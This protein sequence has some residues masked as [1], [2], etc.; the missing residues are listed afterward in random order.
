MACAFASAGTPAADAFP[1]T[2]A[3]LPVSASK[4]DFAPAADCPIVTRR[5]DAPWAAVETASRSDV[6]VAQAQLPAAARA[7]STARRESF[8]YVFSCGRESLSALTPDCAFA[9][10]DDRVNK[11][12]LKGPSGAPVVVP[13]V[14]LG[15]VDEE[16]WLVGA[17][18]EDVAAEGEPVGDCSVEE[19]P[20]QA[21]SAASTITTGA[22]RRSSMTRGLPT[23]QWRARFT[24]AC[25]RWTGGRSRIF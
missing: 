13:V 1:S 4:R 6:A 17:G 11:D 3:A 23:R 7:L 20:E 14:P 5:P 8:T 25:A 22:T 12:A 16:V 21:P 10:S 24:G 18:G 15:A 2:A 9:R 19:V